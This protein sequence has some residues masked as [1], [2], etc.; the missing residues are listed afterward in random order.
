MKYTFIYTLLL[1]FIFSA[2][3]H[4]KNDWGATGH[5]VVGE[6]ADQY[7]KNSTK[8]KIK[9]LLNRESLAFT[10]TF[11]D[12]IKSDRRYDKFFTWHFI[13]MPFDTKY[14]NSKK[15][16][17]G[18][19]VTGIDYC[20]KIIKDENSSD[21]DKAFYLKFLIHLIG[22]LHQPMHIGLAE[23]RGGN[24][25]KLQWK[26]KDTNLHRVWDTEMI[27]S[28][29]MSYTELANN[30]GY[31]SNDEV[32]E[33]EKGTIAPADAIKIFLLNCL[34]FIKFYLKEDRRQIASMSEIRKKIKLPDL[35]HRSDL[36]SNKT[37]ICFPRK[38]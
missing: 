18:D 5:R 36:S 35:R 15:N 37:K 22:D 19:L 33:I 8:R 28:Y 13:N 23:D 24:D 12:E 31:L 20:I 25:I 9:K 29:N 4:A 26:S 6:I 10:S 30:I 16:P 34:R 17:S 32:K 1:V 2:N 7:L 21:S 14:E 11:A 27:E 38:I 3:S